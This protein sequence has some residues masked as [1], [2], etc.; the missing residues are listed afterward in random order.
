VV[1][2][3][4]AIEVL[5]SWGDEHYVGLNGLE[6]YGPSGH[7][8]SLSSSAQ[9]R[10][11]E[12]GSIVSIAACPSDLNI[13]PEHAGDPRRVQNLLDGLSF[14]K[15][16]LHSWLVPQLPYLRAHHPD[17]ATALLGSVAAPEERL[18]VITLEFDRPV[19]LSMCRVFNYNRSRARNQRGVRTCRFL[20]DGQALWQ[21]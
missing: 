20:L 10:H 9:P 18:A 21:G 3:V 12:H 14:S 17:L 7:L 8:F 2:K 19:E 15:N 6:L 11:S 1:G 13:L 16:D 4:L 5:S